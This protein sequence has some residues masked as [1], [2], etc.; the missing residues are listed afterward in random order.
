[1]GR[2][3]PRRRISS[4]GW[5]PRSSR[6]KGSGRPSFGE[7]RMTVAVEPAKVAGEAWKRR[8]R[9]PEAPRGRGLQVPPG[10]ERRTWSS[11]SRGKGR[12]GRWKRRSRGGDWQQ[13]PAVEAEVEPVV[14]PEEAAAVEVETPRANKA[15]RRVWC[16]QRNDE[17]PGARAL[18]EKIKKAKKRRRRVDQPA[19]I[20]RKA[21]EGPLAERLREEKK[22]ETAPVRPG[23][24][25]PLSLLPGSPRRRPEEGDGSRRRRRRRKRRGVQKEE[26]TPRG[27]L[28]HRKLEVFERA[29]LYEGR[30]MR[31]RKKEAAGQGR[32]AGSE[33][34]GD[35]R[36]PKAVKRKIR[37]PEMVGLMRAGQGDGGEGEPI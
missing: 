18:K 29:D 10:R 15:R 26:A 9:K 30:L 11:L 19:R 7:G 21:E 3:W 32:P 37:V 35:S 8:S 25:L 1:M 14:S 6:R 5:C 23:A 16:R 17:S 2:P 12:R 24:G 4:P 33:A 20:I 27:T 36:L 22:D 28:R 31:R 13:E 34:D